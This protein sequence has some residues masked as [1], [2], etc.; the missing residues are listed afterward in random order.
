MHSVLMRTCLWLVTSS[1]TLEGHLVPLLQWLHLQ[2]GLFLQRRKSQ[3]VFSLLVVYGHHCV[4][5][6]I[7]KGRDKDRILIF[8]ETMHEIFPQGWELHVHIG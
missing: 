3:S 4:V 1:L 8:W 7:V 5:C 2:E 6:V